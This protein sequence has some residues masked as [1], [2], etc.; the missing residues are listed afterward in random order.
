MLPVLLM[1]RMRLVP[2]PPNVERDRNP[3]EDRSDGID[4]NPDED[5]TEGID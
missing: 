2:D 3:E 1:D 5:R 4:W